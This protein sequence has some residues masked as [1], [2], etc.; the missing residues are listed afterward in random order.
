MKFDLLSPSQIISISR[1][2]NLIACLQSFYNLILV[3]FLA[4]DFLYFLLGAIK[5]LLETSPINFSPGGRRGKEM[6]KS[7][8]I[9]LIILFIFPSIL[10]LVNPEIF[11]ENKL[12]IPVVKVKVK[13]V[14]YDLSKGEVPGTD[15][16]EDTIEYQN[17]TPSDCGNRIGRG[18]M[19]INDECLPSNLK[20]KMEKPL[21]ARGYSDLQIE[22][23]VK[24]F[25]LIC[26]KES[27]GRPEAISTTDRCVGP[28]G[29]KQTGEPF[30]IGLFQ[31]NMT[32][33]HYT[34]YIKSRLLRGESCEPEILFSGKNFN[35]RVKR[36]AKNM[37]LKCVKILQNPDVNIV[38]ALDKFLGSKG[39]FGAWSV[40]SRGPQICRC[41]GDPKETCKKWFRIKPKKAI[42][43]KIGESLENTNLVLKLIHEIFT[44][45]LVAQ[46]EERVASDHEVGGSIPSEDKLN[47]FLKNK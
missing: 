28:S 10:Q 45:V 41:A 3:I 20:E 35:C 23:I 7:A 31:I 18:V 22:T 29:V 19:P 12:I 1:C 2:E 47:T 46:L 15:I 36:E 27:G 33:T 5:Y 44:N 40:W 39:S 11:Q 13:K 30:S 17:V 21:K 26:Y 16:P 42:K 14:K 38:L 43:T 4:L 25:S 34:S 8:L 37:Y 6:M 32:V 24:L 9:G